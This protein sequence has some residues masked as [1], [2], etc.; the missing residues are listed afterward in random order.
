MLTP[1]TLVTPE[2]STTP[3]LVAETVYVLA[4]LIPDVVKLPNEERSSNELAPS[5]EKSVTVPGLNVSA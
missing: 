2:R 5:A 1:V 3:A 4:V